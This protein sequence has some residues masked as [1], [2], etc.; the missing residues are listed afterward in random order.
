METNRLHGALERRRREKPDS[1]IDL[2]DTNFH[3]NGFRFPEAILS[4]LFSEYLA[5]R[6]YAPDPKGDL[7][8]REAIA[9]YYRKEGASIDPGNIF[10]T[11]STSE[12]YSL[13]F[14][15]LAAAGDN[16]LLPRP[17]YPLF[18][19]L[20]EYARL[21]AKFYDMPAD[22]GYAVD[23]D[24]VA[25]QIDERTRFLVVISPNNP[26]GQIVSE[27]A[28]RSILDLCERT[29]TSIIFDEV[30]SEFRYDG[31]PV[32]AG[33]KLPRPAALDAG[34]AVFTL[35]GIS[36]MFACPDLKL[37]WI[38]LSGPPD[39]VNEPLEVLE[40]ANDTFLNCSSLSQ[41]ILPGLFLAGADFTRGMVDEVA[42]NR[43]LLL[44]SLSELPGSV[45]LKPPSGGIHC[46]L[47]IANE[48]RRWED[49]EELAVDLLERTGVYLH[50]GYF[51]G[52]DPGARSRRIFAVVS[53]LKRRSALTEGLARLASFLRADP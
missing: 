45:T 40:V 51:Y 41:S 43:E 22:R 34:V 38:A 29:G 35:N 46:I 2:I 20:A 28:L 33:G 3:R 25:A 52:L 36:K 37:A 14:T 44:R 6:E 53:F 31:P 24:S 12:S 17:T 48:E 18:E 19:Y 10:L 9:S 32:A 30:F 27:G 21:E 26:T 13:L 50:P 42:G 15:S 7:R 4:R 1:I 11:A 47:E 23:L 5:H 39:R 49:D 8:A 16:V